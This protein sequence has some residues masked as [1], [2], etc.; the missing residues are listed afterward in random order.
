MIEIKRISGA[1]ISSLEDMS[2]GALSEGYLFVQ[3]TIDAWLSG[4]RFLGKG[5]WF[6]GLYV[7]ANLIGIGGLS[8]D[9][10]RDDKEIGRVRHL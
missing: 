2:R 8:L 10:Y 6:Q 9:P 1:N 3:R 5:E 4:Q 7:H